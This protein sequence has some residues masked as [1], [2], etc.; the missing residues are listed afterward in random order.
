MPTA[1]QEHKTHIV[2]ASSR[3]HPPTM[4]NN[5]LEQLTN[6]D[7]FLL[8]PRMMLTEVNS[9]GINREIAHTLG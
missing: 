8:N 4:G 6:I 5:E 2:S 9:S 3:I 1:L 7:F